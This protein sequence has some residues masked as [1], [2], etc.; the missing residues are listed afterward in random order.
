VREKVLGRVMVLEREM[1]LWTK[2]LLQLAECEAAA[3]DV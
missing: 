1:G 2:K 3:V